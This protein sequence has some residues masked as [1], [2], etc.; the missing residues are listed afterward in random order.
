[1]T[2]NDQTAPTRRPSHRACFI[3]EYTSRDWEKKA[4]FHEICAIR[5]SD[6][7]NLVITI[8]AGMTL[9]GKII[10]MPMV[11][12]TN[13]WLDNHAFPETPFS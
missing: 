11:E 3:E 1:M 6:K 10:V 13:E 5:E 2:Q 12:K 9:S 8:P 7:W 4:K